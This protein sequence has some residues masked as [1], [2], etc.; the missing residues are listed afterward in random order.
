MNS[1]AILTILAFLG[2]LLFC[3]WWWCGHKEECDCDKGAS[4][5]IEAGANTTA[6]S[7][8]ITFNINDAG[9]IIGDRWNAVADSLATLVRGGKRLEIVGY[10]GSTE[11]NNTAFENLGLARADT[12]KKMFLNK[13]ADL[14]A[15][16]LSTRGELRGDID[17]IATP[18]NAS[19]IYVK[20]TVATPKAEGGVVVSD[21]ND[22]L[23]YFP[24]G[25]AVKEPSKEVDDFLT[26]LGSRLNASGEKA[27]ITGHT[28]NKGNAAKNLTLSKDRA[29]FVK[30]ILVKHQ[31]PAGNLNT[32]GKGDKEPIGDNNTDAGRRQNRRVRIQISK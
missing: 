6:S 31:A 10:Y 24:S 23:I 26:Q 2:W 28:D 4:A 15:S 30:S 18:I 16:R 3:N 29:E 27:L 7:N 13:F 32:D 19:E 17:G 12:I 21:S 9:P 8:V 20:D 22:I 14:Q 1:K 11:K 25:S 5:T